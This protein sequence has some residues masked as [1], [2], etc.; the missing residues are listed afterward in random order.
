MMIRSFALRDHRGLPHPSFIDKLQLQS[1]SRCRRFYLFWYNRCPEIGRLQ[2]VTVL[3][4]CEEWSPISTAN[5]VWGIFFTWLTFLVNVFPPLFIFI[6]SPFTFLRITLS[7]T[8]TLI[9]LTP[10]LLS[11]YSLPFYLFTKSR[12]ISTES[13]YSPIPEHSESCPL[14][15][16]W[17]LIPLVQTLWIHGKSHYTS[18]QMNEFLTWNSSCWCM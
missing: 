2:K 8:S 4:S 17:T 9:S 1:F 14:F 18:W 13:L 6:I 16:D 11:A 15:L 10:L 12:S 5:C 3:W 7:P